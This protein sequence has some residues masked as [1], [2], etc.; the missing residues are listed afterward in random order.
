MCKFY[1]LRARV[2]ESGEEETAA[3]GKKKCLCRGRNKLYGE[4]ISTSL[5]I[6]ATFKTE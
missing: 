2:A 6:N 1:F 5:T 3:V 4:D